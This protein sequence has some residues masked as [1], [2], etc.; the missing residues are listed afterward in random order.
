MHNGS[1]FACFHLFPFIFFSTLKITFRCCDINH[2]VYQQIWHVSIRF[3]FSS[4]SFDSFSDAHENSE[5]SLN[6]KLITCD[7]GYGNEIALVF[8]TNEDGPIGH[9]SNEIQ[10]FIRQIISEN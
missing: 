1:E 10:P 2:S 3:F 9:Q 7:I 8:G 4:F 5:G 6:E